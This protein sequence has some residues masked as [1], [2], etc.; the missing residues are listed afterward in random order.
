MSAT[1]EQ[2][3]FTVV[4]LILALLALIILLYITIKII[5][6]INARPD[7]VALVAFSSII[8]GIF[9]LF[10]PEFMSAG[11]SLLFVSVG[12]FSLML[13]AV[14]YKHIGSES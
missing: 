4:V 12:L 8:V 6:A 13:S 7:L 5:K 1:A 11:I 14:I 2:S 10:L 9:G 3:I